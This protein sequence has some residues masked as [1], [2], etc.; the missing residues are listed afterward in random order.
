V[1]CRRDIG[2]GQYLQRSREGLRNVN[3]SEGLVGRVDECARVDELLESVRKGLSGALVVRGEA[4]VG[5]T[6][7]LDYAVNQAE[8]FRVVRLTG[9]ELEQNLGFALLHQ[10]LAPM[11]DQIGRL[12]SVQHDA[13]SSA[14]GLAAGPPANPFLVGL[15]VISMTAM[16]AGTDGRLLCI[17]DDAQWADSESS[18]ALAFWARRLHADRVAVIFGERSDA[19]IG[20]PLQGLPV[21]ELNGLGHP[22]ARALLVS[23]VGF[24]LDRDVA[25]RVLAETEG[26]PLAIIE[27]AKSLTPHKLVGWAAAPDPLPLTRRLEERFA[28]E[29]RTLPPDTR[30]F[31]LLVAADTSGDIAVVWKAAGR[32]GIG[33]EA[34]EAGEAADLISLGPPVTYRHPLIRS[35][36]YGTA[37]PADRRAAHGALAAVTGPSDGERWVWHRAGA[38]VGPDEEVAALLENC[39]AQAVS[40][41][42]ISSAV[43]LLTRAAR[44]TPDQERAAQRRVAAAEAAIERGSSGQARTL[45]Q[46]GAPA[47]RDAAWRA[48]VERVCGLADLRDGNLPGAASRLRLAAEGLLTTDP[49][50]GRRTLL[51]AVVI[52]ANGGDAADSELMQLVA[53]TDL[54]PP[55]GPSSVVDWLLHAFSMHARAGYAAAVPEYRNAIEFC[56]AA[57]PRELAPWIDLIAVVRGAVWDDGGCDLLIQA[58]VDWSRSSGA[59]LPLCLALLAQAGAATWRGQLQFASALYAQALDTLTAAQHFQPPGID[60][61]LDAV[62]G[63]EAELMSKVSRALDGMGTGQWGISYACHT[64]MLNLELGHARY[65]KA[66]H[67][68][69]LLFD[70][71]P[72]LAIPHRLPDMIEAAVRLG[73]STAAEAAMAR[74]AERATAARTPWALGLLARS[75]ALM[76]GADAGA[77]ERYELALEQLGATSMDLERGRAH[78]LYGEW[79]RRARRHVDARDHLRLANEMFADMGAQGFAERARVELLATGERAPKRTVETTDILTAQEA[80]VARL[81]GQGARNREIAAQLF[82]SEGTVEY[83]LTKVFRKLGV[84]SRMQLARRT[85]DTDPTAWTGK[86]SH[87]PF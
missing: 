34:A 70:A 26:N 61:N 43:A 9:L 2:G 35:A 12:P 77:E 40:T 75:Q 66:L 8:D 1:R 25:D 13:L 84:K 51:E 47:L 52:A 30:M 85:V 71:D 22:E 20:S 6:A 32:L 78:L 68:A 80:Q 5:K 58:V 44:L 7:L 87:P 4:G 45:V 19:L 42:A 82:I 65:E 29:V 18:G 16:A 69:R 38:A 50:L 83:H 11:L 41:G 3:R 28:G 62:T 10:L 72:M 57:Q 46:Q 55:A 14:L 21:L 15:G 73:D 27:V 39:A 74:L 37:R 17:V 81:A 63:R 60:A 79:L 56:R 48:R 33:R 67:H 64:A 23:E 59:L 31:L 54:H 24:E 53:A 76:A 49:V 36:V 86:R